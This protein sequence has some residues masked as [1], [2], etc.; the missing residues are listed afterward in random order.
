MYHLD[1]E[2]AQ[3][4]MYINYSATHKLHSFTLIRVTE[5]NLRP[6]ANI[7]KSFTDFWLQMLVRQPMLSNFTPF[8]TNAVDMNRSTSVAQHPHQA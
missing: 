7:G 4:G 3:N 2:L 8:L 5:D 6:L 1:S